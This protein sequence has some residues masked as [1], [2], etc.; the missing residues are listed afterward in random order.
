MVDNSIKCPE[1]GTII[2]LTEALTGPIRETLRA[3][4]EA[5]V[6]ERETKALQREKDLTSKE[7]QLSKLKTE[8]DKEV[9][10]QLEAAREKLSTEEFAKAQVAVQIKLDDLQG[11]LREKDEKLTEANKNELELRKR[12]RKLEEKQE[13][14]DLEIARKLSEERKKIRSE[15]AAGLHEQHKLETADLINQNKMLKEQIDVLKQKAEQGSEQA[16]GETLEIELEESLKKTFPEDNIMPVPKGIKG[17]DVLHEVCDSRGTICGS[18][19]WESKRTKN[20]SDR[21]IDKVKSDQR[22]AKADLAVILTITLPKGVDSFDLIKGVWV[23]GLRSAMGVAMAL[24]HNLIHI[25][26]TKMASV[27]KEKKLEML[28]TYLSGPEFK[29]RVEAMVEAFVAL[30]KEL[31]QEKRAITKLWGQRE[32]QIENVLLNLSGM[33]GEFQGII[34]ASLPQIKQLEIKALPEREK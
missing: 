12:E 8:I 27:G 32:K 1:C 16:Q 11:Q 2:P 19:I 25:A 34:G 33:Y 3:E 29:G 18:I 7:A 13:N 20:W 6:K 30:K 28:Y 24:R 10:I 17:G 31:D 21:W 23:T 14:V 9:A 15:A 22:K 5:D 4:L 26:A